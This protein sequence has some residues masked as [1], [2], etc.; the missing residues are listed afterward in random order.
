[1]QDLI[2]LILDVE[3][4]INKLKNIADKNAR[5]IVETNIKTIDKVKKDIQKIIDDEANNLKIRYIK[6]AKKR[7]EYL[8]KRKDKNAILPEEAE[9]RIIE[10]I[11]KEILT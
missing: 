11:I 5:I 1:M 2:K 10:T 4:E 6:R 9:E 3:E 8:K 7:I